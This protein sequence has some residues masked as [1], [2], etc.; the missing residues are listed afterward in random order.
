VF[1][2]SIL[3]ILKMQDSMLPLP[4]FSLVKTGVQP[5]L[6]NDYTGSTPTPTT[7]YGSLYKK[8]GSAGLYWTTLAGAEVNLVYTPTA[9][10][11]LASFGTKVSNTLTNTS[12]G[13]NALVAL[14]NGTS[15][16]AIQNT[17]VGA[18]ALNTL[19][20]TIY[21]IG[22]TAIGYQSLYA[23][24]STSGLAINS[25][26]LGMQSLYSNTTGTSNLAA[27]YQAGYS[28]TTGS[29][30]T[31]I[32][33][34]SLYA[35]SASAS[36]TALGYS[37]GN[38]VT[39]SGNTIIGALSGALLSSENNN[40][41]IDS[42]GLPTESNIIHIGTSK[43]K[44]FI[45]GIYGK[46][47]ASSMTV[48]VNS[49]GQLGTAASSLRYKTDVTPVD[50]TKALAMLNLNPVSFY[51]KTDVDKV[52]LNYGFIAEE[53]VGVNNDLVHYDVDPDDTTKT[54]VETVKYHYIAPLLVATVKQLNEKIISLQTQ[55]D[56]LNAKLA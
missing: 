46:T 2:L 42:P 25:T 15:A 55:V 38:S 37:A 28:N 50:A 17:A 33:T 54:R 23:A 20:D 12:A 3:S 48:L 18:G 49:A 13:T 41:I 4:T 1:S 21:N 32:G 16:S 31:A 35:N 52:D 53:V 51:Y 5:L 9:S 24:N 39:G 10:A 36:N 29:Y 43:L 11:G 26:G 6:I 30:N 8:P 34:L 19:T 14:V 7:T 22:T 56:E 47:S 45:S 27:G 44:C 40:T